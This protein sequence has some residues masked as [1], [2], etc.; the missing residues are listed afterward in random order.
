MGIKS[1]IFAAIAGIFSPLSTTIAAATLPIFELRLAIPLGLF[2]FHLPLAEVF[3]LSIIGNI[4][5]ILPLLLFYK[6]FFHR[7]Q[8]LRYIGK[9]FHWWFKHVEH[10]SKSIERLGFWGL[11]IFV[12]IPLPGTGAWTGVLAATLYKMDIKK[13]FLA[14]ALG[15]IFAGIIVSVVCVVSPEIAESLVEFVRIK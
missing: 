12:A 8:R 5:P 3:M 2:V 11:V 9:F 6:Y 4:I 7:L 14:N 13:A 1:K 10:K 15:V